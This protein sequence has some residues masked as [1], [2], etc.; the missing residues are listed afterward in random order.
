MTAKK[1]TLYSTSGL[2]VWYGTARIVCEADTDKMAQFIADAL[3]A[4]DKRPKP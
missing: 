4:Y 2:A 3:N 1:P